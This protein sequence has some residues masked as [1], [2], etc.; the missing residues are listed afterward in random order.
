MFLIYFKQR[1]LIATPLPQPTIDLEF[2]DLDIKDDGPPKFN[3]LSLFGKIIAN[4]LILF[5][6]IKYVLLNA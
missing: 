6:S 4:K 2:L 5:K 1:M 3:T